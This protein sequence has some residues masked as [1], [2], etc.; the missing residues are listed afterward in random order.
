MSARHWVWFIALAATA[1]RCL[2]VAMSAI[3]PQE[4]YYVICAQHP[5][6]AYFDGP[7]GTAMYFLFAE[8]LGGVELGRML[9]PLWGLAATLAVFALA[10][11][12]GGE[13]RAAWCVIALNVLPFFNLAAV[14][15]GPLMPALVFVALGML[16]CWRV[17]Q[18]SAFAPAWWLGGALS[19]AAAGFFHYGA[20]I[21]GLFCAIYVLL[22]PAHRRS[23]DVVGAV[24][25]VLIIGLSLLPALAWNAKWDWIPIAG[26]TLQTLWE[27]HPLAFGSA[28]AKLSGAI[29]TL[30]GLGLLAGWWACMAGAARQD[31]AKRF[32]FVAGLPAV[33]GWLYFSLRAEPALDSLF[34]GL[35]VLLFVFV[36]LFLRW[37]KILISLALSLALIGTGFALERNNREGAGWNGAAEAAARRIDETALAHPEGIFVVAQDADKAAILG[38]YLQKTLVP[39]EDRPLVYVRESQD[40]SSQFALWPSYDD[41]IETTARRD[42][43]FTEQ[44]GENP[45]VGHTAIYIG[46][47]PPDA[48]PQGIKAAF[49]SVRLLEK[50][51]AA[52]GRP[53]LHI[54]QCDNYQ[55]MPL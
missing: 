14:R 5:A 23:A 29:S 47:E 49:E 8:R 44:K 2:L 10:R 27:F 11:R 28:L 43:Y 15:V 13:T 48:L 39:A 9:F 50:L 18:S 46:E 21:F 55:T 53:A 25:L 26:G 45:F 19:F 35:P 17:A 22:D 20:A 24:G 38:Y 4:S 7:A 37:G 31:A 33:L 52:G 1:V 36:S 54:Y 16:C 51:E 40:I 34:L 41:F 12:L 30:V 6:P 32:A 3:S 42:E